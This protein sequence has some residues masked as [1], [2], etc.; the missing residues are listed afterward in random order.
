VPL[1][2]G[3]TSEQIRKAH[4]HRRRSFG[5]CSWRDLT[6]RL[7]QQRRTRRGRK[8]PQGCGRLIQTQGVISNFS[9]AVWTDS[10]DMTLATPDT[11]EGAIVA[12]KHAANTKYR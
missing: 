1:L 8:R 6:I 11:S 7:C 10:L 9:I 3:L 4:P 5:V 2:S 12:T